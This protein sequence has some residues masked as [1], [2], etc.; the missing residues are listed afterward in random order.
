MRAAD[1]AYYANLWR[2]AITKPEWAARVAEARDRA[3]INKP[4]YFN[5]AHKTGIAWG[6]FA[7]THWLEASCNPACQI[8]NGQRWDT[9]TTIVPKGKG[10]FANWEEA[11]LYAVRYMNLTT[12]KADTLEELLHILEAYN[13]MGYQLHGINSPYLCSGTNL[14]SKGKYVSDG[15]YDPNAISAQ[16]GC[17]PLLK[18]LVASEGSHK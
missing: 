13:G 3:L 4:A 6:F 15:N 7:A 18:A 5:A 14:Y 2:K 11:A 8:L 10:P 9:V 17:I 12:E 16:V 1:T